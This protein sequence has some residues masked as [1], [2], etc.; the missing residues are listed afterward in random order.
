MVFTKRV[1]KAIL[2]LGK[3]F[4]K[5]PNAEERRGISQYFATEYGIAGCIGIVDGTPIHFAQKPAIDPEVY[6]S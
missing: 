6:Y 4:L 2:S 5:W 1:F 3:D